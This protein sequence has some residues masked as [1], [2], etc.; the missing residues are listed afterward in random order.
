MA[1][2]YHDGQLRAEP[3]DCP[4]QKLAN[5][6]I[7]VTRA[8]SP[9]TAVIVIVLDLLDASD[10]PHMAIGADVA[11]VVALDLMDRAAQITRD[12]LGM[13]EG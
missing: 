6:T 10:G 5:H 9:H 7:T 8:R 4:L 11:P 12:A 2:P 1:C 3:G 13:G